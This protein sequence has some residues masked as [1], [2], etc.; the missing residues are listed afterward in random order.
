L[1]AFKAYLIEQDHN[2]KVA[3]WMTKLTPDGLDPGEVTIRVHYSS[4]NYKDA[5]AATGAGTVA[6]IGHAADAKLATT[7]F[8]FILRGASLLGIDSGYMGFPMRQRVWERLASDLKPR[9]LEQLMRTINFDE[10]PHAFDDF[11][12]GRATGRTVVRIGA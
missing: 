5:L 12:R 3:G 10:L 9:H 2:G 6:S 11:I 1:T 7:V 8:P 4:I